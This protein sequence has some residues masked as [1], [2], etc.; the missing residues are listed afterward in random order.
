M[1]SSRDTGI[2][3]INSQLPKSDESL[4]AS[5]VEWMNNATLETKLPRTEDIFVDGHIVKVKFYDTCL[6]YCP[7][8]LYLQQLNPEI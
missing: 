5:S 7:P 8:L 2:I 4:F 6:L 3:P 1:T